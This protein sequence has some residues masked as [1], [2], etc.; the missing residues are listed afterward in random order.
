[1]TTLVSTFS[2]TQRFP[3]SVGG[4]ASIDDERMAVDKAALR[5]IGKK[6]DSVRD[7]LRSGETG[8]GN[9]SGDI[10]VAVGS[11]R[12]IRRIHFCLNPARTDSIDPHAAAAPLGGESTRQ[13]NQSMLRGVVSGAVRNAHQAC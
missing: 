8:H 2:Q 13:P 9:A 4:P 1:M 11:A 6:G 12:L 5:P 7:V 10:G 3:A